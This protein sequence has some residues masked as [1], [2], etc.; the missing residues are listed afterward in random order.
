MEYFQPPEAP[1]VP[2]TWYPGVR[3]N[4]VR[5]HYYTII[6]IIIFIVSTISKD[7]NN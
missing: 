4:Q 5:H 3:L 7:A 1:L 2:T 6:I